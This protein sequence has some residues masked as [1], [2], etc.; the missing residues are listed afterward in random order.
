MNKGSCLQV[1]THQ[2]VEG[3]WREGT[4]EEMFAIDKID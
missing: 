3:Q 4:P 2:D 1:N